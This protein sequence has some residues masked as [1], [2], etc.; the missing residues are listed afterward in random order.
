M[1]VLYLKLDDETFNKIVDSPDIL[2]DEN[3]I[4]GALS[5]YGDNIH[6]IKAFGKGFRE[7]REIINRLD[8]VFEPKT[9]TWYRDDFKKLH[10]VKGE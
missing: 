7:F 10:S 8:Y 3:F 4:Q 1:H 6:L 5:Q 9:I 2:K